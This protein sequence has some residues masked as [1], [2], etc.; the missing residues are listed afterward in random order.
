M[1]LQIDQHIVST[2]MIVDLIKDSWSFTIV[3]IGPVSIKIERKVYAPF[4]EGHKSAGEINH[5]AMLLAANFCKDKFNIPD[6]QHINLK[7]PEIDPIFR[8]Q[9]KLEEKR[10]WSINKPLSDQH[11]LDYLLATKKVEDEINALF[12]KVL[13]RWTESQQNPRFVNLTPKNGKG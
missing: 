13:M 3:C 7:H 11:Q 2:E 5:E 4:P 10:L 12:T 8:D 6:G 9:M 1:L